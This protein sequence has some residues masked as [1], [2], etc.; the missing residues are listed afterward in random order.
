[1]KARKGDNIIQQC[2]FKLDLRLL[3]TELHQRRKCRTQLIQNNRMGH[4][5]DVHSELGLTG[6]HYEML[7]HLTAGNR[8]ARSNT[9]WSMLLR[10][11]DCGLWEQCAILASWPLSA[12]HQNSTVMKMFWIAVC[13]RESTILASTVPGYHMSKV[14]QNPA[15]KC[16]I[17]QQHKGTIKEQH[18]SAYMH[19]DAHICMQSHTTSRHVCS[20]MHTQNSAHARIYP[21]FTASPIQALAP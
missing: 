1:M 16:L 12:M 5:F 10:L 18:G 2:I 3:L 19:R 14:I 21:F 8:T 9:A 7:P 20:N 17:A 4:C 11:K 6:L 13:N 15:T